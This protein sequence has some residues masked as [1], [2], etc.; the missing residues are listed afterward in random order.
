MFQRNRL[1]K[2]CAETHNFFAQGMQTIEQ[3]VLALIIN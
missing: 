3:N 2:F 1:R